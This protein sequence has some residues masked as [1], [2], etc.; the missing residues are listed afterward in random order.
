MGFPQEE[1]I[2]GIP[3]EPPP[4]PEIALQA[5]KHLF[6]LPSTWALWT[7][8]PAPGSLAPHL[9]VDLSIISQGQVARCLLSF[10]NYGWPLGQHHK[11]GSAWL[12]L[13]KYHRPQGKEPEREAWQLASL[14]QQLLLKVKT[15]A[16][17]RRTSVC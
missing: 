6:S 17:T 11:V 2:I 3:W 14:G 5:F 13:I 12:I 7:D 4:P 8:A 10:L 16:S 9:R 15:R 1:H